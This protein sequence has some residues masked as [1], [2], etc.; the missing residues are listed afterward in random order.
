MEFTVVDAF[1][2][3]PFGG[4]PA[5]VIVLPG[6]TYPSDDSLQKIA[7]EFNLSETAFLIAEQDRKD[8]V[9]PQYKLRWFTP[10]AEV[11]LCGHATLASAHTLYTKIFPKMGNTLPSRVDFSTLSGTLSASLISPS[12][13]TTPPKLSLNFPAIETPLATSSDKTE[14]LKALIESTNSKIQESQVV[15]IGRN[16][17]DVLVEL[18]SS[19]DIKNLKVDISV[20]GRITARVFIISSLTTSAK[21]EFGN[22]DI[23]FV[24]R[25]FGPC[26]GIPEDPV[27]G[28]A[29]CALAVY[30]GGKLKKWMGNNN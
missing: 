11:E 4:N 27:T 21:H 14:I 19:V 6:P 13:P 30:Y 17:S 12:S 2:T 7:A 5:A 8:P 16:N 15:F 26:V 29:H 22:T 18:D 10:A 3:S 9:I 20:I 1:T 23:D 28:S 24:S 25:V